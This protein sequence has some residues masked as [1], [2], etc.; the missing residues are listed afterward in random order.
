MIRLADVHKPE[1]DD[2]RYR[3][4]RA[5][6][7]M[8]VLLIHDASLTGDIDAG[9]GM[10]D[11]AD[12]GSDGASDDDD[13]ASSQSASDEGDGSVMDMDDDEAGDGAG[14]GMKLAACSIAFD[15]G[16]FDDPHDCD[17]LSHFLEHMVFMGSE[18]FPRE[19]YFGDWLNQHWGSDNA[20]T[21]SEATVFYFDVNPKNLR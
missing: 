10:D 8:E 6:N 17:G 12:D 19:N 2:K 3:R 14:G 21:D 15:V 9:D 13:G 1:R 16:Y 18:K 20:S 7:G 5:S 4:C 11:D